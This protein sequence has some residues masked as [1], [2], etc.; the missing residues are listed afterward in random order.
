MAKKR[1]STTKKHRQA[2]DVQN[3]FKAG[4]APQVQ[5]MLR[6]DAASGAPVSESSAGMGIADRQNLD[7][8][9]ILGG[10]MGGASPSTAGYPPSAGSIGG[11]GIDLGSILGGMLGGAPPAGASSGDMEGGLLGGLIG[12]LVDDVSKKFGIPREL[13]MLGAMFLVSKLLSGGAAPTQPSTGAGQAPGAPGEIDL[14]A[15]LGGL[16]GGGAAPTPAQ[17]PADSVNMPQASGDQVLGKI[18]QSLDDAGQPPSQSPGGIRIQ[19]LTAQSAPQ[20]ALQSAPQSAHHFLQD[21]NLVGEFAQI[22]GVD[23]ETAAQ[24]LNALLKAMTGGRR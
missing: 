8:G 18:G 4:D 2:P 1:T 21:G 16:L 20:S 11:G 19:G 15:I 22:A 10:L 7:L 23:E 17:P 13:A 14:G 24:S 6:A 3:T 5:S 9:Q 12:P